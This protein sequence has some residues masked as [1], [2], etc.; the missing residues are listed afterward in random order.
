MLPTLEELTGMTC[1]ATLARWGFTD[2][3]TAF[4]AEVY[5]AEGVN[6]DG[7]IHRYP[8]QWMIPMTII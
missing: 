7:M 8:Y 3:L 2:E 5:M 6:V 4:E 1:I